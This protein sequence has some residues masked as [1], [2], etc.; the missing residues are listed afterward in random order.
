M[1]NKKEVKSLGGKKENIVIVGNE[2]GGILV[3]KN[4]ESS[5]DKLSQALNTVLALMGYQETR[6]YAE[7]GNLIPA[8]QKGILAFRAAQKDTFRKE[9]KTHQKLEKWVKSTLTVMEIINSGGEVIDTTA[10]EP[11][12]E[13]VAPVP[14]K[15]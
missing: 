2:A 9:D 4:R 1:E 13:L 8:H 5:L 15:A 3:L 14:A 7:F 12:K 11:K 6:V 10:E